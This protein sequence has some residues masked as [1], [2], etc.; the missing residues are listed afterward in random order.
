M[1]QK[2]IERLHKRGLLPDR[3]YYQLTDKPP[4]VILEEQH[5][6]MIEE[7]YQEDK[8]QETIHNQLTEQ[9]K[10]IFSNLFKDFKI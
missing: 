2:E 1:E 10:E 6:K 3:Y 4:F 9:V 8:I 7:L 5:R